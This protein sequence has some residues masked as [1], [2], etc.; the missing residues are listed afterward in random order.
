[1]DYCWNNTSINNRVFFRNINSNK[2]HKNDK[3]NGGFPINYE[4]HKSVKRLGQK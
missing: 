1:M 3:L 4:W 2:C